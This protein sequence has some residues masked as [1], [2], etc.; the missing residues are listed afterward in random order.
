MLW[1]HQGGL[2]PHSFIMSVFTT[3]P[4]C[5]FDMKSHMVSVVNILRFN[6]HLVT[7]QG[8]AIVSRITKQF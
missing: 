4:V 2:T 1:L 6:G 3:L 8:S 5:A 7:K